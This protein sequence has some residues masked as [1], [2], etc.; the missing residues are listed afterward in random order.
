MK[1]KKTIIFFLLALLFQNLSGQIRLGQIIDEGINQIE[2]RSKRKSNSER[3]RKP[4]NSEEANSQRSTLNTNSNG[5]P[6]NTMI[7]EEVIFEQSGNLKI[8]PGYSRHYIAKN[9]AVDIPGI[10]PREYNPKWRMVDAASK[11]S[12]KVENLVNPQPNTQGKEFYLMIGD[13][14]GKATIKFNPHFNCDCIATIAIKDSLNIIT[15]TRQTFE[16][17]DFQKIL[18]DKPTG[19]PCIGGLSNDILV[20]GGK[21]GLISLSTNEDGDLNASIIFEFY[22]AE[23]RNVRKYNRET[24]KYEN[25][26]VFPSRVSYRFLANDLIIA[27]EMTP[28]QANEIVRK[29]EIRK[30]ELRDYEAKMT[31]QSDSLTKIITKKY[32][33]TDCSKCFFNSTGS[34]IKSSQVDYYYAETGDFA[35]TSTEY[36]LNVVTEIKNLCKYPLLFVG[37]KQIHDEIDGY[38]LVEVTKVMPVSYHYASNQSAFTA[39]FMSVLGG[40][41]EFNIRIQ[42]KHYP[43]HA[44]TGYTQWLKVIQAR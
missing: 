8:N 17:I 35:R 4:E 19:E 37:I 32:N 24:R 29:E 34:Y 44:R 39:A 33:Q 1:T 42:D 20:Q 41:S 2:R 25:F 11:T 23:E 13:Y 5:R 43:K 38:Q 9:L 6:L 40:G 15:S 14:K 7:S 28:S 10:Y 22:S 36:D 30:K 27:N 26:E 12:F 31:R 21:G 3:N 18:N 16:L